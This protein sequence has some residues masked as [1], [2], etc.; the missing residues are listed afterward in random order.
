MRFGRITPTLAVTDMAAA[1][2]FYEG[3]LGFQKVFENGDPVS[4]VILKRDSAEFHVTTDENHQARIPNV[5]HLMVDDANGLHDHLVRHGVSIVKPLREEEYGLLGFVF[6]DP[7]GN[8]IDVGQ[9][10]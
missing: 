2:R 8:R 10:I 3:V 4:F 5:A 1:L 6:A 7:D 9:V